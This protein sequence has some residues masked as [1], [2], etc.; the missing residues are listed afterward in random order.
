MHMETKFNVDMS[1]NWPLGSVVLSRACFCQSE[2]TS[3]EFLSPSNNQDLSRMR[4]DCNKVHSFLSIVIRITNQTK[5][6]LKPDCFD[7]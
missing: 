1:P 3:S 5:L 2:T 7:C 4:L 6:S